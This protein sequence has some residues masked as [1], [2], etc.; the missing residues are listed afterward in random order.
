MV[1]D[2]GAGGKRGFRVYP[3]WVTT[4]NG[5]AARTQTWQLD[6]FLYVPEDGTP[7]DLPRARGLYAR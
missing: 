7:V 1:S 6:H 2:D 4:T 3:P 5:Q